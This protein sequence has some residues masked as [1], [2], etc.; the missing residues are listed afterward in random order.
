MYALV[1]L[2][3]SSWVVQ[4]SDCPGACL[5]YCYRAVMYCQCKYIMCMQNLV[6]NVFSLNWPQDDSVYKLSCQWHICCCMLQHFLDVQKSIF[7]PIYKRQMKKK[8]DKKSFLLNWWGHQKWMKIILD[9]NNINFAKIDKGRR[10]RGGGEK[11][12]FFFFG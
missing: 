11:L 6:W 5:K 10:G 7:T 4:L 3:W 9:V 2:G 1:D 8:H 12:L